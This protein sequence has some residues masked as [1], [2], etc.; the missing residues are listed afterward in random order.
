MG[1]DSSHVRW[2]GSIHVDMVMECE[3]MKACYE[4]DCETEKLSN[5]AFCA[6]HRPSVDLHC[7]NCGSKENPQVDY[8]RSVAG[9]G[10]WVVC[11]DC[12]YEELT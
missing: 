4:G 11:P 5:S 10:K 2:L 12:K 7:P 6:E 3:L 1:L 9:Y 8:A